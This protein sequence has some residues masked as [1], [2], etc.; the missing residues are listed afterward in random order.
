MNINSILSQ[1]VVNFNK[2]KEQA[3]FDM[4]PSDRI[5]E[6]LNSTFTTNLNKELEEEYETVLVDFNSF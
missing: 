6:K 3:L 1:Q 2:A 5:R 4:T